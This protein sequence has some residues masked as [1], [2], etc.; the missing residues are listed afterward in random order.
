MM[1]FARPKDDPSLPAGLRRLYSASPWG[2]LTGAPI[3]ALEHLTVMRPFFE[4][5]CLVLSESGAIEE[6]ARQAGV[7]VWCSPLAYRG[8]RHAGWRRFVSCAGVVVRSRW[9]Y[10]RGLCRLLTEKPGILHVHGLAPHLPYALLAGRMAGV[11]VVV[12][13]HDPIRRGWEILFDLLAIRACADHV[14]FLSR[15]MAERS[16][17]FLRRKST[18]VHNHG[19]LDVSRT[20]RSPK[21]RPLVVMPA[22]MGRR[23]GYDLFLETCRR[24]RDA[25][26]AFEAWMVGEWDSEGERRQA[27]DFLK[28]HGLEVTV[29]IRG[30]LADMAPVYAQMD[31]LLLTSRRDPFPRVIMEA[32]CHGIPVVATRVDGIPEMVED[33]STGFL[34]EAEDVAGLASSVERLLHDEG[35]RRR[36]G[37]AG[38]ERAEN[39]FSPATY[40]RAMRDLY[41]RLQD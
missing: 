24:L 12:T 26:N 30:V 41:Q 31:V 20:D 27:L 22:R 36:M 7:P 16:P 11:P 39:L 18:V 19:D 28:S 23:K 29:S 14:V 3:C 13:I 35:L 6:R 40:V 38:R 9:A 17:A 10:F 33:G 37:A 1:S 32:M 5:V 8:L 34:A 4:E 2:N 21:V 15:D 25:G